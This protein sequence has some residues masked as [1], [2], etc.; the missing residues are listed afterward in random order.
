MKDPGRG[1]LE[2]H[3]TDV[4]NGHRS[5][6]LGPQELAEREGQCPGP[7]SGDASYTWGCSFPRSS[8]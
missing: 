3:L 4:S 2:H 1:F 5:K 8:W 6:E 7:T